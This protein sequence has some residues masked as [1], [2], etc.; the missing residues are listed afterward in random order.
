MGFRQDAYAKVWNVEDKGNY[1][2]VELSTSKKDKQTNEYKTDF[3]SKFVRFIGTA[4]SQVKGLDKGAS[5]KLGNC[6]VTNSYNKETKTSY[7]NFLVFSFELP[8]GNTSRA[9]TNSQP[10]KSSSDGFMNIPDGIDEEL[11]FN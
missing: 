5:I 4:H 3:S 6:E 10:Q 7:T 2:V 9:T 8:N 1:S 11:P